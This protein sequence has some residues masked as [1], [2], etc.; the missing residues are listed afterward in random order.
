MRKDN[1]KYLRT[2]LEANAQTNDAKITEKK[3]KPKKMIQ[4]KMQMKITLC[5]NHQDYRH[6]ISNVMTLINEIKTKTQCTE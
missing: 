5:G 2:A 6:K 3:S 1:K 4:I